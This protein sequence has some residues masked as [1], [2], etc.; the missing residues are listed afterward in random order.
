M[1]DLN[2]PPLKLSALRTSLW[3]LDSAEHH[4]CNANEIF[5]SAKSGTQE[6]K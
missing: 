3:M 5:L 2:H 4:F 1:N 6:E